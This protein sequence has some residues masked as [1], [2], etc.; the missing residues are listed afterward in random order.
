MPETVLD[1]LTSPWGLFLLTL[2]GALAGL[3][4]QGAL[5][6][7]RPGLVGVLVRG[8]LGAAA[9]IWIAMLLHLPDLVWIRFED[10]GFPLAYA[11]LGGVLFI[12]TSRILHI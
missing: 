4:V 6:D 8:F 1:I 10:I 3:L 5:P 11:V 12:L 7:T 9:G 2:S